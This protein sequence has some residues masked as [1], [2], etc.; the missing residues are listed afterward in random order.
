MHSRTVATGA[1]GISRSQE[2]T[3]QPTNQSPLRVALEEIKTVEFIRNET[4]TFTGTNRTPSFEFSGGEGRGTNLDE[5]AW[6]IANL[7]E[8]I[9]QQSNTIESVK[10]E[11]AEVRNRQ[12]ALE[13]QNVE[14]QAEIQ[15]LRTTQQPP[16]PSLLA[17]TWAS[18]ATRGYTAEAGATGTHTPRTRGPERER[19]CLRI[20]TQP[21]PNPDESN[22]ENLTRYLETGKANTL[23]QNT[24][25]KA[26]ST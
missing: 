3:N 22:D 15:S 14:L 19:N 26:D 13:N 6:L 5:V 4:V 9:A 12:Q 24:F 7:K 16:E 1:D 20:S 23:I 17:R 11:L 18:V 8:I 21:N 25:L 2:P 10:S